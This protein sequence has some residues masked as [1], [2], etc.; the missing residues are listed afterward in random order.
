MHKCIKQVSLKLT[1]V[2]GDVCITENNQANSLHQQQTLT[3]CTLMQRQPQQQHHLQQ[4][5]P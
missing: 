4:Q 3:S 1:L 2:D 5:W